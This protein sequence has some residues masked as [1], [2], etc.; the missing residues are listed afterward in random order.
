M[1]KLRV[2]YGFAK[3][4]K[5]AVRKHELAIY[6]ENEYSH[7][8]E[9]WIEQKIHVVHVRNQTELESGD[10]VNS[11]RTFTK[12]GYFIDQKP[13]YGDIELVLDQNFK[14]DSNH[15]SEE[16]RSEIREKLRSAYYSVYK[17]EPRNV[18]QLKL[19]FN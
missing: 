12:Y 16:E 17:V 6:F 11:N 13:F 8:N 19:E 9:S 2:W 7:K 3:L 5:K 10:K 18:D 1:S 15:V 14:A 4:T